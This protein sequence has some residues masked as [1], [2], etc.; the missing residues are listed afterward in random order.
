MVDAGSQRQAFYSNLRPR[1]Y[2]FEVRACN[3]DGIWNEA[4][5]SV[6]FS[7]I[8]AFYETNWFIGLAI[9]T[10]GFAVFGLHRMRL[11]RITARLRLQA[12]AQEE[13][14]QRIAVDLHDTLLQGLTGIGFKLHVIAKNAEQSA[15]DVQNQLRAVI[16]QS[17][18]CLDEARRSVWKLRPGSLEKTTNFPEVLAASARSRLPDEVALDFSVRGDPRPLSSAIE[19][20]LLRICEEA[21]CNAAKHSRASQMH[22]ELEFTTQ[23]V[24]ARV[25]DNGRGFDPQDSTASKEGH[26]GLA[27]MRERARSIG[28]IVSIESQPGHGTEVIVTAPLG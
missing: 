11:A 28:G 10:L 26:F 15:A 2:R 1:K 16:E 25:R 6:E 17:D 19:D 3:S 9:L 18:H 5:D 24:R 23:T 21:V 22:I 7:I 20:N 14:R 27:A 8:P 13:E 4:G 12:R